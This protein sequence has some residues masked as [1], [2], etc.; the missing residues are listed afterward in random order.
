VSGDIESG[1]MGLTITATVEV[2]KAADS[3]EKE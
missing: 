1:V 2:I 3:T